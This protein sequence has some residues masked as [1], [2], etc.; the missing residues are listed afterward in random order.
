M[1]SASDLDFNTFLALLVQW[2][3]ASRERIG[4][5]GLEKRSGYSGGIEWNAQTEQMESCIILLAQKHG[6]RRM[7]AIKDYYY[8]SL[9]ENA[10]ADNLRMG[11][12][13]YRLYRQ[14]TERFL[15]DIWQTVANP[16]KEWQNS[17]ILL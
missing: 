4:P 8:Y 16:R 10:C 7:K 2:G 1:P 6:S 3:H 12:D 11:R 14:E 13:I 15:F 17:R 9:S 5:K